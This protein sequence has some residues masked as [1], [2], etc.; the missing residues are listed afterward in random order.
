VGVEEGTRR[1]L[2]ITTNG[3]IPWNVLEEKRSC[4]LRIS[5]NSTFQGNVLEGQVMDQ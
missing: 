4:S 3:V 1:F 5:S 2:R